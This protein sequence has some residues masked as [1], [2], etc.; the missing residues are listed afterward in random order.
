MVVGT[1]HLWISQMTLS[2]SLTGRINLNLQM[3]QH[4]GTGGQALAGARMP[5]A[6]NPPTYQHTATVLIFKST[7]QPTALTNLYTN[8]LT[9]QPTNLPMWNSPN[10]PTY[11]PTNLPT[12]N[13]PGPLQAAVSYQP[14][15]QRQ[16]TR[17]VRPSPWFCQPGETSDATWV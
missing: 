10:L 6:F 8:L 12:W 2:T 9:Y 5:S 17:A 14:C 1:L 13:H 16:A 11:Q 3:S 15:L 4:H 7:Y